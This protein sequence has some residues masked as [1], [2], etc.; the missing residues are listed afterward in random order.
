[1]H[2][3]AGK[4]MAP[5]QAS[6]LNFV[7]KTSTVHLSSHTSKFCFAEQVFMLSSD[8]VMDEAC[9]L[10]ILDSGHS[11]IPVHRPGRRYLPGMYKLNYGPI[12]KRYKP[13]TCYSIS[14]QQAP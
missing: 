3:S 14:N 8:E 1:M 7:E 6:M 13:P 9:L 5:L 12:V 2:D 10:R 4:G 11:R